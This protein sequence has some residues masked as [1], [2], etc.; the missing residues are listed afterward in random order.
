MP[1]H[2][3]IMINKLRPALTLAALLA[4]IS[5]GFAGKA[6]VIDAKAS[7]SGD[8]SYTFSVTVKSDDTGWDKYADKWEVLT[9]DGVVLGTRVLA[10]PHE[11]EQ[12]FTREQSGIKIPEG[13]TEVL[14]RAH[15]KVEGFGG[16]ELKLLLPQ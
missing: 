11:D 12:P 5:T 15:D 3:G 16:K 1:L 9:M 2:T 13:V 7:K 8:G 4:S 6:D 14:I 10:H